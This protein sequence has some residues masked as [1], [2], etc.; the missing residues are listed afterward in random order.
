MELAPPVPIAVGAG[1]MAAIQ[2]AGGDEVRLTALLTQ[3]YVQHGIRAWS[4]V[5]ADGEPILVEPGSRSWPDTLETWLPWHLG[6][7]TVADKADELYSKDVLRPLTSRP[8]TR[9]AAGQTVGSISPTQPSQ[10]TRQA[11]SRRSSQTASDGKPS[12]VQDP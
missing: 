11:R 6:G 12:V 8:S 3:V 7:A 10:R 1:F 2:A 5:D 4:F 9:S